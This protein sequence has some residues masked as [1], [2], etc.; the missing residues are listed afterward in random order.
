MEVHHH[1][2]TQRR[3]W[4]HYFW[5]FLMLFL[6]VFCGFLAENKREHIVE[7]KRAK[8][9]C[10]SLLNDLKVDTSELNGAVRDGK[11]IIASIDT[12]ISIA[13]NLNGKLEV[14]GT[15]YAHSRR[16][17]T[18]W[19]VD[20]SRSTL[21]QLIQ[22]GN[23]RYI[24]NKN[25]VNNINEYYRQQ[26]IITERNQIERELIAKSVELR[27]KVFNSAVNAQFNGMQ[28]D[29][30]ESNPVAPI[31]SLIKLNYPLSPNSS[32]F[33]H[34]YINILIERRRRQI[35][36]ATT[37]NAEA[38]DLAK[39]LIKLISDEYHLK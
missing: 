12:I 23:L 9:Y 14:P 24:R 3:K 6:A 33:I 34:E 10:I 20:W 29:L 28:I 2:Q 11:N 22:S 18:F 7:G 30:N 25:L 8:E 27:S 15:F 16:A 1:T 35:A 13:S 21:L 36:T 32:E 17:T 26:D 37:V 38:L 4:R 5:E 19:A 31:R 39:E